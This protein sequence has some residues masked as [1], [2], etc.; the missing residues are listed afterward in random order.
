MP[1]YWKSIL[2]R[3]CG[4]FRNSF[5][6]LGSLTTTWNQ[7]WDHCGI[8]DEPAQFVFLLRVNGE[9]GDGCCSQNWISLTIYT[10]VSYHLPVLSF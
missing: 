8:D 10:C 7:L 9:L 5:V 3:A 6:T 1:L 2:F 4:G